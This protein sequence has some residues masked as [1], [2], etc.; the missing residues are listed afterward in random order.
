MT[1]VRYQND[2]LEILYKM[3][4][5]SAKKKVLKYVMTWSLLLL[6][7]V[8]QALLLWVA[9]ILLFCPQQHRIWTRLCLFPGAQKPTP[10]GV[11]GPC[12]DDVSHART[13]IRR[14]QQYNPCHLSKNRNLVTAS[15]RASITTR[16]R[17]YFVWVH[18]DTLRAQLT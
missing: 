16:A 10:G 17:T 13:T 9:V 4:C 12:L 2:R 11:W 1:W 8:E 7:L 5:H 3:E 14:S 18:V 15:T 6:F